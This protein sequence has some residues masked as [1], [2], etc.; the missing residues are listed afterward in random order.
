[1]P[2]DD[3]LNLVHFSLLALPSLQM[4]VQWVR[5]YAL[6]LCRWYSIAIPRLGQ[7]NSSLLHRQASIRTILDARLDWKQAQVPIL[8]TGVV[9]EPINSY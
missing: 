8:Y 6:S 9:P 4:Y 5:V 7:S 1:M 2:A 3:I